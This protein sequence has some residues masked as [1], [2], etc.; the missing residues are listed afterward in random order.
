MYVLLSKRYYKRDKNV[1]LNFKSG[2]T[3][4]TIQLE[5]AQIRRCRL[6][7]RP[8]YLLPIFILSVLEEKIYETPS[9]QYHLSIN[10]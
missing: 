10:S 1:V 5:I 2:Q 6:F 3:E 9:G 8:N 4:L 7:D